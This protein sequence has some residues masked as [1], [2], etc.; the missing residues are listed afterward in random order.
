[1]LGI[2]IRRPEDTILLG[3][4]NHTRHIKSQSLK[5]AYD[6]AI[7]TEWSIRKIGYIAIPI[8]DA[9]PVTKSFEGTGSG[10]LLAEHSDPRMIKFYEDLPDKVV[11]LSLTQT[12]F[13]GQ[14][15]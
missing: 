15:W 7:V 11:E 13:E 14:V 3:G 12:S 9:I 8:W 5:I 2:S 1:M 6:E 10:K 4:P